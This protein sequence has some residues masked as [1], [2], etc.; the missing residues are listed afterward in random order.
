MIK[1]FSLFEGKIENLEIQFK[2][3]LDKFEIDNLKF[4]SNNSSVYFNWLLFIY[5]RDKN[6]YKKNIAGINILLDVLND[7]FKKFLR[8][9][10]N[11][12]IKDIQQ[13]KTSKEFILLID[14]YNDYN[15]I[16]NDNDVTL[17]SN[18]NR[19]IVFI[20]HTFKSSAK[21]G[22]DRF[23]TVNDEGYYNLHNIKNKSLVYI[24]HKFNYKLN[25]IIQ[26]KT[27]G[28]VMWDYEDDNYY[29]PYKNN[30]DEYLTKY[31]DDGYLDISNIIDNLPNLSNI[32][33]IDW[34]YN[35]IMTKYK[36]GDFNFE[37]IAEILE[38]DVFNESDISNLKKLI[39]NNLS[40]M[41]NNLHDYI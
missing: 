2:D 18:N 38:V 5:L 20:P 24:I 37:T 8:I 35:I 29:T 34:Y 22:W 21:W 13:I 19:W 10:N 4:L 39:L 36:N 40:N 17:I 11:L 16:E 28:Y 6:K 14:E 15:E 41:S 1:K 12:P 3:K 33:F 32:D 27:N 26:L 31:I 9:K 7:Y 30:V 23:C 25:C